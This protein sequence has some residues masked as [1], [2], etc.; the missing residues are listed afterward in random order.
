[1]TANL[2]MSCSRTTGRERFEGD[3][4]DV[5]GLVWVEDAEVRVS[6]LG[7]AGALLGLSCTTTWVHPNSS[8]AGTPNPPEIGRPVLPCRMWRG[9]G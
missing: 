5:F 9:V 7:R 2:R 3:T 8:I 1:M 4:D 6:S